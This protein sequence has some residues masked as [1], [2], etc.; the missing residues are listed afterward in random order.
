MSTELDRLQ[1]QMKRLSTELA[2]AKRTI[3]EVRSNAARSRILTAATVGVVSVLLTSANFTLSAPPVGIPSTQE[4]VVLDLTRRVT[5]LE[6]GKHRVTAPFE[7]V[8]S[9]GKQ[10]LGVG[11]FEG[12]QGISVLGPNGAEAVIV[13]V[14][15]TIGIQLESGDKKAYLTPEKFT[16]E[17]GEEKLVAWANNLELRE[18]EDKFAL[19]NA[20]AIGLVDSDES[21]TLASSGIELKTGGNMSA[22]LARSSGKE[23]A[24]RIF[25]DGKI[26][27]GVGINEFGKGALKVGDGGKIA[28]AVQANAD[29]TGSIDVFGANGTSV[30]G[31]SSDGGHGLVAV[32][33][34]G[35]TPIAYLTQSSAGDGGNVTVSLNSGFGVFS[36][37]AAQDGAGEACVNR[38]TQAGT[39]R[40]ACLGLGLPS[41]GMGK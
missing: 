28:A 38:K 31:I 37:G 15:G 26:V 25:K 41:A 33:N 12:G 13:A 39:A 17:K 2:S 35:G 6:Q 8:D 7:V 14:D 5:A 29:G 16:I 22:E 30:A 1:T 9:G 34:A 18:G 21:T 36:A 32:R 23:A 10:I 4:G 20:D 19:L 11:K 3:A 24:L 40:L 27:A